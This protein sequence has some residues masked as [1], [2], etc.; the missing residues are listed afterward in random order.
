MKVTDLKSFVEFLKT[1][2]KNKFYLS[3]EFI[4]W[5][6]EKLDITEIEAIDSFEINQK[7]IINQINRYIQ[8]C[9]SK[10][11]H[12][13]FLFEGFDNDTLI[14]TKFT[15]IDEKRELIKLKLDWRNDLRKLI[16]KIDWREFEIL[17]KA[18]LQENHIEKI[19]VTKSSKDQGIDFF[20]YFLIPDLDHLPRI[21]QFFKF[22]IIGQV[23]H[24]E[25]NNGVDHSKVASFGTEINKL[26]KANDDSYF[27]NLDSDFLNSEL[28]IIGLFITNS[29]YPNKAIE[30]AKE[31]GIVYWD[32]EQISQDL[33]TKNIIELIIDKES[34][35]LSLENFKGFIQNL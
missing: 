29:Y 10:Y 16:Q 20:G 34:E 7:K 32:G 5:S 25:N 9:N 13:N 18:I 24:S 11:I 6:K 8:L 23:K 14:N 21:Y 22:R 12:S 33:V 3:E 19:V 17:S 26:R 31:Y 15:E 35:T 1:V 28:P 4:N 2:K 27:K 30:F